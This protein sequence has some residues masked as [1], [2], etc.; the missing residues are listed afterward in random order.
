[1]ILGMMIAVIIL[2][3]AL[4]YQ[5]GMQ[6]NKATS[7]SYEIVEYN[8][9]GQGYKIKIAYPKTNLDGINADITHHVQTEADKVKHNAHKYPRTDARQPL[10]LQTSC[11]VGTQGDLLSVTFGL[12]T[13]YGQAF[14]FYRTQYYH[15][16]TQLPLNTKDLFRQN[17]DY[18]SLLSAYSRKQLPAA[19]QQRGAVVD[20]DL[21][22]K[23][24]SPE[25]ANFQNLS[26]GKDALTVYFDQNQ[27]ASP[28]TG[29]VSLSIPYA[30][31]TGVLN[32]GYFPIPDGIPDEQAVPAS[33]NAPIPETQQALPAKIASG[34]FSPK[35]FVNVPD[36]NKMI[37]ITFDDGPHPERTAKL[38]DYLEQSGQVAT[39]YVL[40]NRA[41]NQTKLLKRMVQ[42]NCE[43]GNHSYDHSPFN[44]LPDGE[45]VE[46]INRT[47]QIVKEATGTNV[48]TV[49]TP[50]GQQEG[51]IV[52]LVNH[53]VVLWNVDSNDWR[54]KNAEAI[55]TEILSGAQPGAIILVHDIFEP[56]VDGAIAAME[57]L[58]QDGYTFVTVSQ[59]L[60]LQENKPIVYYQK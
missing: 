29:T 55:R 60:D 6:K 50:Y 51:Q 3:Y 42:L 28:E 18:L 24:T 54:S 1:M 21:L 4:I 33:G 25:A 37:A 27:V 47:N 5:L 30:D 59:L 48:R 15:L 26:I 22:E 12:H 31:L 8:D 10:M 46:Q 56:S 23:G 43:I 44:K 52:P 9:H 16:P 57:Q 35:T 19:L 41:E 58:R 39:F 38:L 34:N 13:D 14:S 17:S 36:P 32:P 7:F 45:I 53:P 11:Q 2:V 40:G 20:T 49:R